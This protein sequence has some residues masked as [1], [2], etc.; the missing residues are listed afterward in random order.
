VSEVWLK[1]TS[2]AGT[3]SGAIPVNKITMLEADGKNTIIHLGP[4]QNV[5]LQGL[6]VEA[7]LEVIEGIRTKAGLG[8]RF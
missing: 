1:I 6:T 2:P 3:L 7:T 8:E 4:G 5:T